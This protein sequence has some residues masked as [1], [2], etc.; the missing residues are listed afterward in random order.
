M[1]F[2]DA[3]PSPSPA[4]SLE[5]HVADVESLLAEVIRHAGFQ[6]TC[7]A[8]RAAREEDD[9]EAPEFVV[10]L[11][12][13]D[14][15]LLLERNAVLLDAFEHVALKAVRLEEDFFGKIVLDCNGWRDLRIQELKLTAQV[16]AER[17]METRDPFPLGPMTP[18]ERR[19]VHL[20]LKDQPAVRTVS[21]GV[22][23]E[24]RVVIHPARR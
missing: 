16:A 3:L 18:R 19:I 10:E 6:L 8:R 24:R 14:S 13:P 7:Q 2:M 1:T 17:V 15:D 5:R 23:A 21:E 4:R 22:G 20:A 11:S 12:G 9:F